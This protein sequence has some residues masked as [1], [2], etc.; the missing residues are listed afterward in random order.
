MRGRSKR[1]RQSLFLEIARKRKKKRRSENLAS[2]D[3]ILEEDDS[4]L[5]ENYLIK[6]TNKKYSC[7][8]QAHDERTVE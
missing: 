2:G 4:F 8:L 3:E 7:D 6:N 1:A 5:E